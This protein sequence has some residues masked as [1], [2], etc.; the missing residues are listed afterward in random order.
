MRFYWSHAEV[1][2][3]YTGAVVF[4]DS[5]WTPLLD[6]KTAD[7]LIVV[8]TSTGILTILAEG[9]V[10]RVTDMSGSTVEVPEFALIQN[11]PNPF[12][13]ATSI[14]YSV[15]ARSQVTLRI[16][17]LLG[18]EVVTLVDEV[19]SPGEY[20]A[21]WASGDHPTGVYFCRMTAGRYNGIRKMLVVK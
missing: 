21:R 19:K 18:R 4:G 7:S 12:N 2:S 20:I 3:S 11:Y 15:A 5:A 9:P 14:T 1:E 17:D 6:M 10:L 13:P 8:D 16:Y